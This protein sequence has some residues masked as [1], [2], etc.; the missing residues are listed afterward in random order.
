MTPIVTADSMISGNIPV[1]EEDL[2]ICDDL[3]RLRATDKEQVPLLCFPRSERGPV[4]YE[5]F[6][7]REIYRFV[8]HAA[9]HYMRCGLEPVGDAVG[10][11]LPWAHD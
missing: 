8:D 3:L 6:T 2:V 5:Q 9:K 4:E 11:D 10:Q 7:G 1:E